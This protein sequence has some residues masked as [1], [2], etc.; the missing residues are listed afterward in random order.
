VNN[1]KQILHIDKKWQS[2]VTAYVEV[3]Y[4]DGS[5]KYY[6]EGRYGGGPLTAEAYAL[7]KP[8]QTSAWKRYRHLAGKPG[9]E[10]KIIDANEHLPSLN[11]VAHVTNG[12]TR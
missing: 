8:Y 4:N 3:T 10:V 6:L 2:S 7:A 11:S 1:V 12:E 5:H 9:I